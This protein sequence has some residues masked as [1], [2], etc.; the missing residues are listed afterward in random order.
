M[1]R[2]NKLFEGLKMTTV[3]FGAEATPVES[4]NQLLISMK[5]SGL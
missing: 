4:Q 5:R 3:L 2:P 1:K